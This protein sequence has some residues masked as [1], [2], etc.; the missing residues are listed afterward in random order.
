VRSHHTPTATLAA[1]AFLAAGASFFTLLSWDGL[2]DDSSAYLVPLFWVSLVVAGMG[3]GLRRVRVPA[4]AVVL[5]QVVVVAMLVHRSWGVG[6][7]LGGWLPTP[8][9]LQSVGNLMSGAVDAT[10]RYAA[11]IPAQATDFPPL[12]LASGAAVVLLVDLLACTLRR[13]PLAGLPLLAAF[14]V[15]VSVLGGVSWLAFALAAGSFVFL[16][17][18]DQAARLGTWGRSLAGSVTD[19][20]PHSVGLGT[21]WPTATRIGFAGIGL[22]VLA[23]AVLPVGVGL[24]TGGDGTGTGGDDEVTISNPMLDVR[25][26]LTRGEDIPLLSFTTDDPAPAYLRISVLDEFNGAAWVPSDRDIPPENR[27]DGAL[28]PA[29]GLSSATKRTEYTWSIS[30]TDDFRSTWLPVPYPAT[31]LQVQGDW[32]YDERTLDFFTPTEDLTT[33]GLDYEVVGAVVH[34]TN[35]ALV[36]APPANR[37]VFVN[38][39]ALPASVPSWLEDLAR[40][41][42]DGARSNFERAVML[43]QWF[44]EDGG[45][46]Y[47]TASGE[48]NGTEQLALFLGTG[49]DSRTGYCE[50]FAAAMTLLAR[51]LGIPARIAVGFLRPERQ[52]DTWVY[53]AHDMHAWP[54]IYFEGTGWV[55]FEPTPETEAG[56][57]EV[58]AYTTGRVPAPD[59]LA[60]PSASTS[61]QN[62]D[63]LPTP[64]D[65]SGDS[66][67]A[68][69]AGPGVG[70]W[71]ALAAIGVLLLGVLALPRAVR[72]WLRRRRLSGDHPGGA[73]EG[74]WAEVRA[75]ALDLGLGWDD[76]VTLRRRARS[77]SP[78]LAP[79]GHGTDQPAGDARTPVEALERLVLLVERC[80]FSRTGLP[81]EAEAEVPA[82]AD[83][84]TDAMRRGAK[85]HVQRRATW[86]PASLWRSGYSGPRRR[87][88]S[89]VDRLGELDRVSL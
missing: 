54:E 86:L 66:S 28:P 21:V 50:Q 14:T 8:A 33:R 20:Q 45:F 2:S 73:A 40:D 64:T 87:S 62:P 59:D 7:A 71:A 30:V 80:R 35:T 61:A 23:P 52:G 60:L 3:L 72:A 77:L 26:D 56:A 4:V 79:A 51:S 29:P 53:S 10:V 82:L 12:M 18:A 11:P 67:S 83:T 36:S 9:S 48:G 58:P 6:G 63:E 37:T 75:T 78:I 44:R 13:V 49:P 43:Q 76:G 31:N 34:A 69:A 22:A 74:G 89:S 88:T 84:V 42:T 39:T 47:S 81:Q 19:S 24:F 70:R 46:E 68:D 17:A 5:L 65:R 38:Q 57:V 25:R 1:I 16:L 27:A 55:R 85:P 15:P 32:R 41:I